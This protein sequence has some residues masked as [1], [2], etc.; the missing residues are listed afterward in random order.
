MVTNTL[1]CFWLRGAGVVEPPT[2]CIVVYRFCSKPNKQESYQTQKKVPAFSSI[3]LCTYNIIYLNEQISGGTLD[4]QKTASDKLCN[5]E[6]CCLSSCL[7][8]KNNKSRF[9][10]LWYDMTSILNVKPKNLSFPGN[11]VDPMLMGRINWYT[12]KICKI[13]YEPDTGV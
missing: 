4:Y 11:G 13:R 6:I 7:R 9:M 1:C 3:N 12:M 10:L 2:E 8:M 5:R